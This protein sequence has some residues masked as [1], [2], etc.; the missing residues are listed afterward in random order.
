MLT[1]PLLLKAAA[2]MLAIAPGGFVLGQ[3]FPRGLAMAQ[4]D[5]SAL[6]PWAWAINGAMGT[7]TAGVAPLL[8]Q[9]WGFDMLFFVAAALYA[10]ILL[11]PPYRTA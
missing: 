11:L 1:W 9:A 7:V 5:D 8:A 2:L 6:V 3:L 4:R 10:I